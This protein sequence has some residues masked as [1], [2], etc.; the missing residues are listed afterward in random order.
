L[1]IHSNIARP[2]ALSRQIQRGIPLAT[3]PA[4]I[5]LTVLRI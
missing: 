2:F 5:R 3:A 4:V 1:R